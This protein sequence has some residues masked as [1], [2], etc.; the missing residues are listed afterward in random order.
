[1]PSEFGPWPAIHQFFNRLS[2]DDYFEFL[3]DELISAHAAEAVFMDSTHCKVHQHSNGPGSPEDQAIGKSRGGLNTK[4]HLLVD[5]L[6]RLAAPIEVTSG[7]VS[8]ITVAPVLLEDVEDTAVVGDKGYDA[9]HLRHFLAARGTVA[10]IPSTTTRKAAIPHDAARY[11]LRNVIERTFC[12]IKDF[13]GIATR[14]DKT[15]RNFL[16]AVCLVSAITYWA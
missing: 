12:R 13:R 14:Y 8:D 7:N 16:A 5:V 4:I 6:G 2:K 3:E 15:A 10:V 1:M 11:K 9:N